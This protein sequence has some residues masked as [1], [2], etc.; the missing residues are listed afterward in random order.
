MKKQ[1]LYFLTGIFIL[2]I[3]Y[4]FFCIADTPQEMILKKLGVKKA[5]IVNG[6]DLGMAEACNYGIRKAFEEGILTSASYMSAATRTD[7]I[8]EY[9]KNNACKKNDSYEKILI[10]D[11]K[12]CFNYDIGVHLTLAIDDIK[13]RLFGPLIGAIAGKSLIAGNGFFPFDIVPVMTN[14]K[15]E[16][17]KKELETQITKALNEGID[18]T[19]LDC[20]K[21]W[22]HAYD[23]KTTTVYLDLAEKYDLPIR[24][25]GKP[26][27]SHLIKRGIVVPNKLIM[28]YSDL[29]RGDVTD[30]EKKQDFIRIISDLP[31]GIYEFVAHPAPLGMDLN[32]KWREQELKV[33]LDNEVKE[34]LKKNGIALIGYKILRDT[35]RSLRK[36]QTK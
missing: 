5:L 10:Q 8:V 3:N 15:K 33:Y 16:E 17:M 1:I 4:S 35:Q 25:H 13:D 30:E 31:D 12:Q 2:L 22:C 23:P 7:E 32:D 27:D 29:S 28:G 9:L 36:K 11:G 14:A 18:V 34:S 20:H 19:H 21:G 24:W 26:D 6:D